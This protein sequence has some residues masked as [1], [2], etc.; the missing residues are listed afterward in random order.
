VLATPTERSKKSTKDVLDVLSGLMGKTLQLG[1][2]AT[3]G[4]GMCRVLLGQEGV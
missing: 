1:G 3:T 2:K 4:R